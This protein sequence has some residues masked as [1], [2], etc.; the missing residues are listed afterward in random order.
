M[1]SAMPGDLVDRRRAGEAQ[2]RERLE[3]AAELGVIDAHGVAEDDLEPLEPVDAPLDG[4]RREVDALGDVH[5]RPPRVVAQQLEDLEI[6]RIELHL[7]HRHA[8]SI[9][10]TAM[11]AF[12]CCVESVTRRLVASRRRPEAFNSRQ[13]DARTA[14]RQPRPARATVVARR[15]R[16]GAAASAVAG[17][18]HGA[19]REQGAHDGVRREGRRPRGLVGVDGRDHDGALLRA[20]ARARPRVR[21]AARG[22]GPA[23]HQ[24][25]PRHA[26]PQLPDDAARVRRT[27]ELSEP[28]QGSRRRRLLDGLRRDRRHRDALERDRAA[29]RR[30]ATSTCRR[31]GATSRSSATPSSTR[32]PS[33]RR[34]STRWS[35]ASA[36]CCGSS[37][38]TGSRSIA[39]CRTWRSGGCGGCSRR[40][41]G[42]RSRSS[43]GGG[44]A[45]CSSATAARRCASASTR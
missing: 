35:R 17:D 4:R 38:S 21:E 31:A 26:R 22:A 8:R 43:T 24:L 44:C 19:P 12:D 33:G 23:R 41:A 11:L 39:S 36:R 18:E 6:R 15:P 28:G 32:A 1:S 27:A 13:A 10:K 40:P 25:P 34:S 5:E 3:R 9:R 30:R 14:R 7:G 29:L 16:G 2:L 45:R 37:T 20:S 42:R